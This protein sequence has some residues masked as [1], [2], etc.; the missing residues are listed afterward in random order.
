MM[1]TPSKLSPIRS[2]PRGKR[3][4]IFVDTPFRSP[5]KSPKKKKKKKTRPKTPPTRSPRK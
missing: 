4:E 5:P 3:F 2:R 1:R